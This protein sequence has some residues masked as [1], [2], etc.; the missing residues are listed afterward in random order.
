MSECDSQIKSSSENILSKS[1]SEEGEEKPS[2][3]SDEIVQSSKNSENNEEGAAIY[4][5]T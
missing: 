5:G 3:S 2:K 4:I 1:D